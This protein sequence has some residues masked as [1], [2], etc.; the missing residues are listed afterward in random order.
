MKIGIFVVCLFFQTATYGKEWKSVPLNIYLDQVGRFD[1]EA[2]SILAEKLRSKFLVDLGM[3]AR[4]TLLSVQQ[5]YGFN[6]SEGGDRTSVLSAEVSREF[7]T[8]GT[9]LSVR[10]TLTER[11]D[12]EED[13][14]DFRLNQSLWRN[15]FGSNTRQNETALNRQREALELQVV[16]V[17]EDY[18]YEKTNDYVE[19]QLA[20][21]NFQNAERQLKQAQELE[22]NITNRFRQNIASETDL[23]RAK[24]QTLN[25]QESA[26]VAKS[27]YE[28]LAFKLSQM[29]G[30]R[31]DYL[32]EP[33]PLNFEDKVSAIL[34]EDLKTTESRSSR[35]L[36]LLELE[37]ES[38]KILFDVQKDQTR[39][40]L[41][42]V[43]GYSVD[44]SSRFSSR[45]NRKEAIVGFRFDIPFGDS[46][47]QARSDLASLEYTQ[48]RLARSRQVRTFEQEVN[49]AREMIRKNFSQF[50]LIE[51]RVKLTESIAKDEERRYLV[52]RLTLEALLEAREGWFS[53]QSELLQAKAELNR[54]V[55][56]WL[57][58]TDQLITPQL[59]SNL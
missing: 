2:E 25:R 22:R 34:A 26:L 9:N 45:V 59:T 21:L 38:A 44:D 43:A 15:S 29:M 10:R 52:G 40:D 7:S 20:K 11:P 48:A 13:A 58:L 23:A 32:V 5:E 41:N 36:R 56:N 30:D 1:P 50:K 18:L 42:L 55:L 49:E 8:T 3:P 47:N 31:V 57:R 19:L 17:Y 4:T 51:E 35:Q 28:V 12:R 6:T 24:V 54:S 33:A 14:I 37:E 27:N 46:A 53:G 16:E 39:P